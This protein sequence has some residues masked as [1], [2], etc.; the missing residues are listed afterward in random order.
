MSAFRQCRSESDRHNWLMTDDHAG[1]PGY[2]LNSHHFDARSGGARTVITRGRR[3]Q[4][5]STAGGTTVE[6]RVVPVAVRQLGPFL[7]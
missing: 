5:S 7:V 3:T 6:S 2:S 1:E 4:P